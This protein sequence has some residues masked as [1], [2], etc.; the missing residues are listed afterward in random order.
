[1]SSDIPTIP[2]NW[3][4]RHYQLDALKAFEAGKRRQSHIW[5]RRAGK[6]SFSLNLSAIQAHMEI[7][8]Y[9]HL[10]PLQVQARR[11]IWSG[12]GAD[13][14][15]FLEQAFP[16]ELRTATR[17]QEMQIE[18]QCGS[19]WQMA[20]SDNYDA[21][22]GSNVRGVIFSE[23]ALC[24][25]RSWDYIRPI[26]RE[27]DG[28]AIFITTY[29]GKNHAW[30]MHRKVRD[31]PDWF[32]STFDVTQTRRNNGEPVLTEA[33]IQA[34]RDEGMTEPMIQQEYYCSPMAAFAGA[35]WGKAMRDM[36]AQKRITRVVYEPDLP[37][38][39]ALDLGMDDHMTVIHIQEHNNEVRI[40]DSD[41]Y[42]FTSIPD[43][44]AEIAK[45]P[46]PVVLCYLPHDAAVTGMNTGQTREQV[47]RNHGYKTVVVP[48]PAGSKLPGIETA[49]NLLAQTWI[50]EDN[51]FTLIEAFTGYR[52]EETKQDGVFQKSPA[53]TW[54][55]HYADA[56]QVY[57]K[58]RKK[59]ALGQSA[60][61]DYSNLARAV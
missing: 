43:V 10:F 40:I 16:T 49:R 38:V 20:G 14:K 56:W 29:R 51:N 41:A 25:P 13:G 46:W 15:R 54:E 57:A 23:W 4:P 59:A 42:R 30:S 36:T 35:F 12:I 48:S 37:V 45:K 5:H 60:P 11:A 61:L 8:T 39:V 21:L 55:S 9:W 58:A 24:D 32:S 1:M 3:Q 44:C 53:H 33:D 47:F 31:N 6:D 2:N 52:T 18:L 26:L 28:W 50:D 17:S 19:I 22:V 34:E 7:G 27:N